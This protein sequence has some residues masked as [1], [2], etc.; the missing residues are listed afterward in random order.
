MDIGFHIANFTWDVPDSQLGATLAHAAAEAESAGIS[1]ITVMDHFW[2]IGSI[3]TPEKPMLEGY[4]ALGFLAAHTQRVLLHTLV[5]G[6]IYREPAI[7]AKQI[8][9]LDV[10]SGGRAG[11]GIGAGWNEEES[12]G[13]GIP[14]PPTKERFERL[15]EALQ[16]CLQMWSDDESPYDGEHYR[17]GRTLN[18]PQPLSKPRPSLM[19]GG[20]GEKK[21]LRFVARYADACNIF[22]SPDAAHKLDVL[23][24]WC[25]VENRDYDTVEKTTT[26]AIYDD[27]DLDEFVAQL[28]AL[29]E[30]GFTT[31]YVSTR[32]PD[33][34]RAVDFLG[35]VVER[36]RD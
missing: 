3:G 29:R 13:L 14:F 23:R 10:L 24:H 7:L 16:I 21:T 20:V 35:K 4:T 22:G 15:E 33:P 30:L 34:L 1:R 9:T 8:S 28:D 32:M 2:Q 11:L 17:L 27:T 25:D 6:V 12:K 5:T 18:S 31:A 36:V 19:I 26:T